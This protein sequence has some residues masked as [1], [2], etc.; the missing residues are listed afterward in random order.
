MCVYMSLKYLYRKIIFF[1]FIDSSIQVNVIKEKT[2]KK[3]LVVINRN[4]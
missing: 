3:F 1:H 2:N 4:C